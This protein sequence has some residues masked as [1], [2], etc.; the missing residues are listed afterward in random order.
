MEKLSGKKQNSEESSGN[1]GDT[2]AFFDDFNEP[3]AL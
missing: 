1:W 2:R 3:P